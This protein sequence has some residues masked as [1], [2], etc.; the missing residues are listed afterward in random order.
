MNNKKNYRL[1]DLLLDEGSMKLL[2]KIATELNIKNSDLA[3]LLLV[4]ELKKIA[5]EG[6]DS[7][8]LA[9]IGLKK[10]KKKT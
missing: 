7:F 9:V 2:N 5:Y 10:D 6:F 3:R 1:R 4:K 8:E